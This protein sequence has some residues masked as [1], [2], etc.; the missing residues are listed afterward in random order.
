MLPF[1]GEECLVL[2]M[3]TNNLV[4]SHIV[5]LALSLMTDRL[6]MILMIVLV[7]HKSHVELEV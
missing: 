6:P 4:A 5:D 1:W 3:V 7:V 2:L